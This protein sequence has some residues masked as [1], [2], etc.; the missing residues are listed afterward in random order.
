MSPSVILS[1][2]IGLS[3]AGSP[4]KAPG[5]VPVPP[6]PGTVVVAPA[7]LVPVP[8]NPN[9]I[10]PGPYIPN[11]YPV[12][13]QPVVIAHPNWYPYPGPAWWYQNNISPYNPV[14]HVVLVVPQ[15]LP[16]PTPANKKR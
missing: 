5:V 4:V 12:V 14:Q 9:F 8:L 15:P 16:K 2:A 6:P 1:L 10:L 7:P 3:A 13:P 11:L